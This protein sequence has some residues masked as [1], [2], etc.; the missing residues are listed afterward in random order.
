MTGGCTNYLIVLIISCIS[1]PIFAQHYFKGTVTYQIEYFDTVTQKFVPTNSTSVLIMDSIYVRSENDS[2]LG[3]QILIKDIEQD[4]ARLLMSALGTDYAVFIDYNVKDPEDEEKKAPVYEKTDE[5]KEFAD[6]KAQKY[7]YVENEKS[8]DVYITSLI[9]GRYSSVHKNLEG[10]PLQYTM[11]FKTMKV[12]YTCIGISQSQPE[13]E[14]FK[15]PKNYQKVTLE[16]FY[17]NIQS[18]N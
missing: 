2:K 12:R 7:T 6:Y 16:E 18:H 3:V 1:T 8:F 10:F 15:I 9:D 11:D 5:Q 4:T 14:L 13:K 17:K